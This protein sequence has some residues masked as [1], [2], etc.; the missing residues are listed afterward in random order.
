MSSG[1][2]I[3]A[4]KDIVDVYIATQVFK[5]ILLVRLSADWNDEATRDGMIFASEI[6]ADEMTGYTR[7]TATVSAQKDL[8]NERAEFHATTMTLT[9]QDPQL[10][11]GCATTATS[12][13]LTKTGGFTADDV[14]MYIRVPGAGAAGADLDTT[15]AAFIDAD[16]VTM[17]D[18]A[19][20]TLADVDVQVKVI[21]FAKVRV[22]TDDTD[23]P[24]IAVLD[25]T[26]SP[27]LPN[28]EDLN[29]NISAEGYMHMEKAA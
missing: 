25:A 20:T 12:T 8:V 21:G 1:S 29:L 26:G 14:G 27:L 11:E 13:T 4:F 18:A 5:F 19:G 17:A 9:A 16:S 24:I 2:P 3:H 7:P 22:V 15:I 28:G 10:I 6:T 23:S